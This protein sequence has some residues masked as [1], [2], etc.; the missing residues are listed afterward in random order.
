[1]VPERF[2]DKIKAAAAF[3]AFMFI[4][5]FVATVGMAVA[6]F[7][8]NPQAKRTSVGSGALAC[9]S[10]A[11]CIGVC[12]ELLIDFRDWSGNDK[13]KFGDN[14]SLCAAAFSLCFLGLLAAYM[15]RKSR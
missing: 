11:I 15:A 7:N 14:F 4:F 6:L 12:V 5:A 10:G 8:S 3:L 2:C 13:L 1:M 9:A